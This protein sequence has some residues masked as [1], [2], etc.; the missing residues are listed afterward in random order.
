ML[1]RKIGRDQFRAAMHAITTKYA[2]RRISWKQFLDE[3]QK[4]AG[5]SGDCQ[6]S[7]LTHRHIPGWQMH[8]SF[9][10]TVT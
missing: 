1:S 6:R 4:A 3:I 9:S 2:G 5:Q 10:W 7:L 8:T